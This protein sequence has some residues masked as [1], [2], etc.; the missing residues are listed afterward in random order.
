MAYVRKT[1]TLV[2]QI[3]C[4]VREMS[5]T[6]QQPYEGATLIEGSPEYTAL[7]DAIETVSWKMAPELRGKMPAEWK[8][9]LSKSERVNVKVPAPK[10]CPDSGDLELYIERKGNGFHLSPLHFD[11][12]TTYYSSPTITFEEEDIPPTVITWF[13][14]GKSN[15]AT[16]A[17]IVA[18]FE[19]IE[20]QLDAF[21]KQHASLNTAIKAMPELEHYVP[22]EY[23]D[24]LHAPSAPRVKAKTVA[25]TPVEDLDIDVDN[26]TS[27]AVA[28]QIASA[29]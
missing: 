9:R 26:L 22:T 19:K 29:S 16:K 11:P 10:S 25:K 20:N 4:H 21:M 3:L 13:Q 1:D 17:G 28:H 8:K 12:S 14:S 6:A 7:A 5:R 24:K 27:M 18:K 23:M 15:E 2:H